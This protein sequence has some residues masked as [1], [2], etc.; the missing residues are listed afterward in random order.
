MSFDFDIS[1]KKDL[2]SDSQEAEMEIQMVK[3]SEEEKV[4]QEELLSDNNQRYVV[5]GQRNMIHFQPPS[6]KRVNYSKGSAAQRMTSA[7]QEVQKHPGLPV[8]RVAVTY[9]VSRKSLSDRISGKVQANL[10]QGRTPHLSVEEENLLE[11]YLIEMSELGFGYDLKNFRILVKM[12]F[13]SEDKLFTTG[14]LHCFLE[15]HP[16][17]AIRRTEALD[18]LRSR[19]FNV[20]T[21]EHYFNQLKLAFSRCQELSGGRELTSNLVFAMDETG[22]SPNMKQDYILTRKGVKNAQVITS[23]DRSHLTVVGCASASGW[24]SHPFFIVPDGKKKNFL[25]SNFEGSVVEESPSGYMNDV[26]FIRWCQFIAK[27][28]EE[29]R[30][31]KS[32][33]ALLILDGLTSHTMNPKALQ[34]LNDAHILSVSIPSHSSSYFQVHDVSIYGPFKKY[35]RSSIGN[36]IREKSPLI[37]LNDLPLIIEEPWHCANTQKNIKAGFKVTGIW[38]LNPNWIEENQDKIKLLNIKNGQEH[39]RFLCEK[40]DLNSSRQELLSKLDY[41]NL[42]F[43]KKRLEENKKSQLE[44]KLSRFVVDAKDYHLKAEKGI[45]Y[46]KNF[47]GE[48]FSLAKILNEQPRI[49]L[50][51]EKKKEKESKKRKEPPFSY[52]QTLPNSEIE[53][54]GEISSLKKMKTNLFGS[55]KI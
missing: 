32:Y 14:W 15:R 34:I 29:I 31:D 23:E 49:D 46:R 13:S 33:W 18:R 2:I 44:S 9:G 27:E 6:P 19:S 16:N 28:I 51:L 12:L 17:L 55:R 40:A 45:T 1:S 54:L 52:S 35:L 25:G 7:M 26:V 42:S 37:R 24:S 41:L 11:N 47:I 53:D 4:S 21:I 30:E 3:S 5:S 50:L 20:Q 48:N 10:G 8:S 43:H 39:F 38:P 36:F 22:L